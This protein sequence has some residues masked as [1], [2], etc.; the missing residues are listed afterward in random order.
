[1]DHYWIAAGPSR[2]TTLLRPDGRVDVVIER[3][4]AGARIAVYGT[5]TASTRVTLDPSATYVGVQFRPAQARHFLAVAARELTDRAL[6][7]DDTLAL[8]CG[9]VADAADAHAVVAT[10]EAALLRRLSRASTHPACVDRLVALLE[11]TN[12]TLRVQQLADRVGVS[13][14]QAERV[15]LDA[16]GVSPKVFASILRF[17]NAAARLRAGRAIADTAIAAGYADQSH[18]HLDFRRY[19]DLTPAR[20]ARETGLFFQD[21]KGLGGDG[22]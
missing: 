18:L 13:R 9:A 20:Y 11:S 14:R 7:G 17:E 2:P 12:G 10:L 19:A 6:P 21:D 16:V 8:D 3:T 5:V 4:S 15:F 1:V 22:F